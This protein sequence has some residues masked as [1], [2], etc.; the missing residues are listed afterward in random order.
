MTKNYAS[1]GIRTLD[2][3]LTKRM[4]YQLS[5]RGQLNQSVPEFVY[6]Y[7]GAILVVFVLVAHP[8]L[9][10]V[11]PDSPTSAQLRNVV[12]PRAFT[13]SR[14]CFALYVGFASEHLLGWWLL[15]PHAPVGYAMMQVGWVCLA[16]VDHGVAASPS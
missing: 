8:A 2:L 16:N 9:V 4:L 14:T 7:K 6:I 11:C 12:V 5:Y 1:A 15:S 13:S 3:S 10:G